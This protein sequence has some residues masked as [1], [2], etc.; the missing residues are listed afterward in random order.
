[1]H[2]IVLEQRAYVGGYNRWVVGSTFEVL[3]RLGTFGASE[4]YACTEFYYM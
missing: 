4:A 2:A 3:T 1:M